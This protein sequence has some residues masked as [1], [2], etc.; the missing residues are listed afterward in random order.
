MTETDKPTTFHALQAQGPAQ[1]FNTF[2]RRQA[3]GLGNDPELSPWA[4]R[5]ENVGEL[6]Q[7]AELTPTEEAARAARIAAGEAAQRGRERALNTP[8]GLGPSAFADAGGDA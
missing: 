1:D 2:I 6:I 4:S 3:A 7:R 5:A 8:D